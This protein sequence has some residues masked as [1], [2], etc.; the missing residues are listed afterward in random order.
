MTKRPLTILLSEGL[1]PSPLKGALTPLRDPQ[2]GKPISL[3]REL[4]IERETSIVTQ[5]EELRMYLHGKF[6]ANSIAFLGAPF[7]KD[8][9][10]PILEA[11][12]DPQFRGRIYKHLRNQSDIAHK[13]VREHYGSDWT[14]PLSYTVHETEIGALCISQEYE[15]LNQAAV[16][17]DWKTVNSHVFFIWRK[18][19]SNHE[20]MSHIPDLKGIVTLLNTTLQQLRIASSVLRFTEPGVS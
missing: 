4:H 2:Y 7:V 6:G 5:D 13:Q 12:Q 9:A 10:W 18:P 3:I 11:S 19:A 15:R 8:I 20:R 16:R 17:K 14:G 1:P